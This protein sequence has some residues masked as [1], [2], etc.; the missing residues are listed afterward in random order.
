VL[1]QQAMPVPAVIVPVYTMGAE[2]DILTI[3]LANLCIWLM[4]MAVYM[5]YTGNQVEGTISACTVNSVVVA[6]VY[7]P[8][9]ITAG[10]LCL[11]LQHRSICTGLWS[12][13]SS[14]LSL[15]A[16]R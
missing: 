1:K 8:A 12:A 14:A 9:A 16:I 4:Y 6:S 15:P 11:S 13:Q 10:G 5:V 3:S 7:S 2:A